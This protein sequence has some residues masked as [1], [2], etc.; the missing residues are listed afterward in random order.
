MARA[1]DWYVTRACVITGRGDIGLRHLDGVRG[2][3][4]EVRGIWMEVRGIWMESKTD[5]SGRTSSRHRTRTKNIPL[6]SS[7][8]RASATCIH[9]SIN[10]TP[11]LLLSEEKKYTAL[12]LGREVP[13]RQPRKPY[14]SKWRK[15]CHS[16]W[17]PVPPGSQTQS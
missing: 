12:P 8:Q 16:G 4:M 9:K 7:R 5:I 14:H 17:T 3:W 15:E 10:R 1:F 2:I 13:P 11:C 6:E